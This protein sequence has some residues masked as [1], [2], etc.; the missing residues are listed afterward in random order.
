MNQDFTFNALKGNAKVVDLEQLIYIKKQNLKAWVMPFYDQ[1]QHDYV[2]DHFLVG[3]PKFRD[4]Y[5]LYIEP[6]WPSGQ[7]RDLAK[8]YQ[9]H[10]QSI[11]DLIKIEQK[12]LELA[13][14]D[15]EADDADFFVQP[16]IVNRMIPIK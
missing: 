5:W 4:E 12:I 6:V 3:Y 11:N 9:K 2:Q 15:Y 14:P 1:K 10:L 8:K 16:I 7:K 13:F